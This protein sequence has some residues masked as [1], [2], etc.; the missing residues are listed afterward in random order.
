MILSVPGLNVLFRNSFYCWPY[1]R[2][3]VI[4]AVVLPFA[5]VRMRFAG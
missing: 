3:I 4:L 1:A 2:M 5:T